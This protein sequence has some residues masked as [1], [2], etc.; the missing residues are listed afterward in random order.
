MEIYS[1]TDTELGMLKLICPYCQQ[2][3]ETYDK[4]K[5]HLGIHIISVSDYNETD[6]EDEA[7]LAKFDDNRNLR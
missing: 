6:G 4:I 1:G 7:F 2:T 5:R 3:F